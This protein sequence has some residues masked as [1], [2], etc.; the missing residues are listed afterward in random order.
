MPAQ[1]APG[2]AGHPM[3]PE[4]EALFAQFVARIN[5]DGANYLEAGRTLGL[6]DATVYSWW[7]RAIRRGLV[8][9]EGPG[10]PLK[11]LTRAEREKR[12]ELLIRLVTL[13]GVKVEEA[14]RRLH[15]APS[16]AFR[17][18]DERGL[19]QGK[20]RELMPGD[21]IAWD[22]LTKQARSYLEDFGLFRECVL[23]RTHNPPWALIIAR[24]LLELYF[25]P[26]EEYVVVNACP[27]VGKSTLITHD[28]IVWWAAYVR[29]KG[30]EP[31]ALLGHRNWQKATWYVK[32]VRMTWNDNATLARL[33]GRFRSDDKFFE[34]SAEELRIPLLH[35]VTR[36]EKE[37]TITAG[38]YD[39][40]LLSGRY[41]VVVWDDLIDKTNSATA[42]QREKLSEWNDNEAESRLEPAG[43]YVVSNA[44]FGPEDLSFTVTQQVDS[45]DIDEET[46]RAR[47]LYKRIRMA[48]HDDTKCN[49][50]EHTG[51]WP[52]GCL[53]DPVRVSWKRLRRQLAK[54]EGRYLLVWQQEDTDPA[55][56]LAERVWFEGG[57]DSRGAIAPGC[58]DIDRT[59]G[60]L[61]YPLSI[62]A[63]TVSAVTVDPSSSKWWAGAHYLG[64]EDREHVVHRAF[65]R[66]LQAPDLLYIDEDNPGGYVGLLEEWWQAAMSEGVPF[67]YLIMEIN[68]A[69]KWAMQYPF[70][71]RWAA[72]REVAL[73]PHTT[74]INKTDTDRG[75]EM[76]RPIYQFG[77]VK[78]PYGGYEEKLIADQWRREACAWP[79]GQTTDEVMQHWFYVHRM[80]VLLATEIFEASEPSTAGIPEWALE[81]SVPGWAGAAERPD[82]GRF[83]DRGPTLVANG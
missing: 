32:R 30:G 43:L 44:R 72:S 17:M 63:P 60:Q 15:I 74:T 16:T 68:A 48:A 82:Q 83:L 26:D 23:G 39:A 65:R 8:D 20:L 28:F 22:E 49:G 45:E 78:I 25:S 50:T 62:K 18:L 47:P 9:E 27:G 55:G 19:G 42:D 53:L 75:V 57:R 51:P 13:Q 7:R 5:N 46:G 73:I 21:P 10:A 29:A 6:P 59:F 76:L 52:D 71:M 54:N 67:H 80:D 33:Y 2:R 81:R 41:G 58:F 56:N 38:S 11:R 66:P 64:Y 4:R 40:S 61:R 3:S 69:Q 79:E 1:V 36:L 77:R 34:W 24:Q 35:G 12:T 14:A 37:P 70:F 31:T